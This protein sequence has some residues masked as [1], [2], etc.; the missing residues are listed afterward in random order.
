MFGGES[1]GLSND[2]RSL[3]NFVTQSGNKMCLRKADGSLTRRGREMYSQ[4]EITVD[5]PAIQIGTNKLDERYRI[6]TYKVFTESEFPETSESFHN[7][8][9]NDVV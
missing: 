2:R 9:G 4:E 1:G 6:E 8:P 5:A 7:T 3:T